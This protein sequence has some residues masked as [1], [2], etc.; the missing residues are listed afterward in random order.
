MESLRQRIL[1]VI[2]C[3]ILV[4]L[5]TNGITAVFTSKRIVSISIPSPVAEAADDTDSTLSEDKV[6]EESEQNAQSS[7]DIETMIRHQFGKDAED[8]L[9]VARCESQLNPS[10]IGDGHLSF[11]H[12]GEELGKSYGLFQIRSGGN[13]NGKIW[14]RPAKLGISL[15]EFEKRMLNPEENVKYAHL[16][17]KG[18]GWKQ[19]TCSK[20][21]IN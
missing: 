21:L 17:F 15:E 6:R 7:G 13:E 5:A 10:R 9:K 4:T 19:W 20:V 14:S 8:A 18:S 3:G 2:L 11:Q 12:N 1:K 16:I